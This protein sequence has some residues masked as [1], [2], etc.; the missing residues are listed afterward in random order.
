MNNRLRINLTA[1]NIGLMVLCLIVITVGS[2]ITFQH[3]KTSTDLNIEGHSGIPFV[4]GEEDGCATCHSTAITGS[5]TS[6][7]PN[8]PTTLDNG[9]LFPHHDRATGGPLDTCSDSS[10][11][12][13]G[14]DIRYVDTPN[15]SHSYCNNCHSSD[16]SHG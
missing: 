4:H 15:A 8:P 11:H 10:C 6:C 12:D 3:R 14:T 5:C 13:S 2:S 16:L 9:I 7:H 1:K